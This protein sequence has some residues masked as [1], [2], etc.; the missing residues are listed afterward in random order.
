MTEEVYYEYFHIRG[1]KFDFTTLPSSVNGLT[2]FDEIYIAHPSKLYNLQECHGDI[3]MS[4]VHIPSLQ[5]IGKYFLKIIDDRMYVNTSIKS[6][7]LGLLLVKELS[8]VYVSTEKKFIRCSCNSEP[9][10]IVNIHLHSTVERDILECQEEL[11]TKNYQSYAK[12]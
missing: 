6:N 1:R 2:F 5:G 10:D 9:F 3:A 7:I 11:I 12:L 4:S 8:W